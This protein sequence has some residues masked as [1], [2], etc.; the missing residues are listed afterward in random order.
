MCGIAAIFSSTPQPLTPVIRKMAG[1][2][3]HRGPDDEGYLQIDAKGKSEVFYGDDTPPAVRSAKLPWSPA[4]HIR[5]AN[6][7]ALFG[8]A[9]RRL[10]IV[11][12]SPF[13]HQPMSYDSGRYWIV[14]NGEIY[15]YIE[16]R[17][18]LQ[19]L[20]HTFLSHTDT[21][22]IL[23]AYAEWGADCLHRFNGMWALAILDQ[24]EGTVFLS[25]DRFGVKP[26]YYCVTTNGMI[27]FASEIKQFTVLPDWHA[28]ANSQRIYDFL[29]W[30]VL[31]HT[32]E[33]LFSG[34]FQM[35]AG[36]S[37]TLNVNSPHKCIG[38]DGCLMTTEWY[39]LKPESFTGSYYDAAKK[40]K[41]LLND[42]V[43]LRLR[44]DVPVGS[45]LSGGLDSSSIVCLM[46]KQLGNSGAN[47]PTVFSACSD[48]TSVDERHWIDMVVERTGAESHKV[49][50]DLQQLFNALPQLTWHQDEP[51]CSTSIYAQW[52][53]YQLIDRNKVKVIING[54]GADEIL[55][56]YHAF[57]APRLTSLLRHGHIIK[58]T[59]EI[60]G[61]HREL[62]YSP[63][64]AAQRMSDMMLP[65]A[66]RQFI[67]GITGHPSSLR[68]SWLN[69]TYMNS[70]SIN[71]YSGV[72]QQTNSIQ[73]LSYSL[74][75]CMHLPML[76]HWEDRNSMAQSVESR[77]PFLDFRIVEFCLSLPDEFKLRQGVTK[78]IMRTALSGILPEAIKKRR[79]KI[80][81]ATPEEV[82]IK[83]RAPHLFR[84]ALERAIE[85]S[86]GILTPN[87]N[88][89]LDD[90][91]EGKRKFDF[92]TWRMISLGEWIECF[93]VKVF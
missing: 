32:N 2:V 87:A 83:K 20:G 75:K 64:H 66:L 10:A 45:C 12:K 33:T 84:K 39:K 30:N 73:E 34:V 54:Q 81:F 36:H 52:C 28:K 72:V 35:P 62:G 61:M 46:S 74:L 14:F 80:G 49:M 90:V 60:I 21:E 16:L 71:L 48:D 86:A 7:A 24:Y 26:L 59:S 88:R 67:R 65:P 5:L 40:F 82:W 9:H 41:D 43:E 93:S 13:G 56:G 25:R 53:V 29:V 58:L 63:I 19:L 91:L 92:S 42:A 4:E 27:A 57:L 70:S 50:P 69:D 23:A 18:E 78:R 31:D 15:N 55:A 8:M 68:K 89:H 6:Q 44:A 85:Q 3:R 76:L 79:D 17:A 1:L 77:M 38:N 51:F 37:V 47:K 22:V 11:D